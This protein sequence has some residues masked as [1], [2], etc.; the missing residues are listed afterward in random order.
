MLDG[1]AAT[2]TGVLPRDFSL[3]FPRWWIVSKRQPV[4]AYIPLVTSA[5]ERL[6]GVQVVGALKPGVGARQA[7]AELRC[8]K[9]LS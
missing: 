7:L 5:S 8:W 4:E 1:R 6:G 2:I 9:R 3:E